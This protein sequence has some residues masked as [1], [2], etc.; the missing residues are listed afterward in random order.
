[1]LPSPPSE[2]LHSLCLPFPQFSSTLHASKSQPLKQAPLY[3]LF[4]LLRTGFMYL[5]QAS[6]YLCGW[7]RL[8]RSDSPFPLAK[9]RDCKCVP[10]PC[11]VYPHARDWNPVVVQTRQPLSQL[12][13]TSP[14]PLFS[15]FI[16]PHPWKIW[17]LC[18]HFTFHCN[19]DPYLFSFCLIT[20]AKTHGVCCPLTLCVSWVPIY[21]GMFVCANPSSLCWVSFCK[22]VYKLSVSFKF[23]SHS[24]RF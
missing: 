7:E 8:G 2:S 23:S 16:L 6:N 24:C 3:L 4:F 5:R 19:A 10:P 13:A 9:F 15:V 20:V 14:A 11:P 12:R 17:T 22:H 18:L 21:F 1:M